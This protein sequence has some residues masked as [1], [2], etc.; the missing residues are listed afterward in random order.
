M[1]KS[2][3]QDDLVEVFMVNVLDLLAVLVIVVYMAH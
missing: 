3:R 2:F 1:I